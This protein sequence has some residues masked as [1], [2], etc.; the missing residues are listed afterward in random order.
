MKYVSLDLETSSLEPKP[1]HILQ[2]S[3]VVEDTENLVAI[4][5]LPHF[6]CFVTHKIITGQPYALGMNGW[7][8]DYISGRKEDSP[9]LVLEKDT[10]FG[11]LELFL[12][13]HFGLNTRP[14]VAGKNVA[15]FDLQFFP[16]QIKDLFGHRTIDPAMLYMNWQTDLKPPSLIQCKERAG[17][18]GDVAHDALEDARDIIRVLRPF[19]TKEVK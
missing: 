4:E 2:I 3:A 18:P 10:A 9:Y 15:M 8:L 16:K 5:E 1:E 19:Y 12:V 6:T 7:I 17:I 13:R 11:N 14:L